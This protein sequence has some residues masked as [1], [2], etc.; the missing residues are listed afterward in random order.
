MA[1]CFFSFSPNWDLMYFKLS[2]K[3]SIYG[4]ILSLA[5]P[6]RNPMSLL[7]SGTIGLARIIWLNCFSCSKAA[8]SAKSV[9]PVPATPCSATNL[10]LLFNRA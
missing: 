8:A 10:T 4:L 1:L 6:G 7:E 9:F 3:G 5:S 2:H